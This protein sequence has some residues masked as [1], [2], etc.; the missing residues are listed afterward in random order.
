M[1]YSFFGKWLQNHF[2]PFD[3][4]SVGMMPVRA[5]SFPSWFW[6]MM[7]VI[8][9]CEIKQFLDISRNCFISHIYIYASSLAP[10]KTYPEIDIFK[11][12]LNMTHY[13]TKDFLWHER[14]YF[15]M[16]EISDS[17]NEMWQDR[18]KSAFT[19]TKN[20]TPFNYFFPY[21]QYRSNRQ[22]FLCFPL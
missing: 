20:Y 19:K 17:L 3:S 21:K 10:Q 13:D 22:A 8:K 12:F 16:R 6:D 1:I 4:L 11:Y 2:G 7:I 9:W 15:N 5:M 18:E 14:N